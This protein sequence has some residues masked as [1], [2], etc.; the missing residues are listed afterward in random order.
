MYP[1]PIPDMMEAPI[2]EQMVRVFIA[3]LVD[4]LSQFLQ[5]HVEFVFV[6][7]MYLSWQ[8]QKV[9]YDKHSREIYHAHCIAQYN[10][11]VVRL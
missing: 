3:C 8:I 10:S 11:N 6:S 7:F 4:C 1:Y 9:K 2:K 5:L